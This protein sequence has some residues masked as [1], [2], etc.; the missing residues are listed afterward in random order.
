MPYLYWVSL[1]SIQILQVILEFLLQ[2]FH[3]KR[4]D[5]ASLAT[6]HH[7]VIEHLFLWSSVSVVYLLPQ[8]S[9]L[10]VS[11]HETEIPRGSK[12]LSE[13]IVVLCILTNSGRCQRHGQVSEV[14]RRDEER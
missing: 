11:Q 10:I 2:V 1:P 9:I 3:I 14:V 12:I 7:E 13:Q 6:I 5:K 4:R 8:L